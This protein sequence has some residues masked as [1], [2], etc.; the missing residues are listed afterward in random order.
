ML[1][2]RVAFK[3]LLAAGQPAID[4][5]WRWTLRTPS[6]EISLVS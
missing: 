4:T 3:V 5:P 2:N 6:R 1:P